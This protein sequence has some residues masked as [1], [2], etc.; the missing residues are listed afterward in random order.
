M[1]EKLRENEW[2]HIKD[3]P[4]A[5]FRH[6]A[7]IDVLVGGDV[8]AEVMEEGLFKSSGGSPTAQKTTLGWILF[9]IV[10]DGT[11]KMSRVT[12]HAC[13]NLEKTVQNLFA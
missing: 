8:L 9:G 12:L 4:L 11:P 7:R 2:S 3:L 10:N 6:S 5:E 13:C 1:C